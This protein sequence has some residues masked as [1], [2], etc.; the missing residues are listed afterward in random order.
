MP[1]FSNFLKPAEACANAFICCM[2]NNLLMCMGM[3]NLRYKRE[4]HAEQ[5]D[6]DVGLRHALVPRVGIH[7]AVHL[8]IIV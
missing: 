1:D 7:V 3:S 8:G 4:Q 2:E 5:N 6:S